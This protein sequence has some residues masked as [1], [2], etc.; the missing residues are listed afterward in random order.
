MSRNCEK[1]PIVSVRQRACDSKPGNPL[2]CL[3]RVNKVREPKMT[4]VR[5]LKLIYIDDDTDEQT[6]EPNQVVL[7]GLDKSLLDQLRD[8]DWRE[9]EAIMDVV[10][11]QNLLD[12]QLDGYT[13]YFNDGTNKFVDNEN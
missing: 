10:P 1:C 5:F 4:M 3:K 2:T 11:E 13:I 7:L 8:G 12:D 9:N 6:I